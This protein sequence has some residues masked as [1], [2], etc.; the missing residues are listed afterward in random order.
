MSLSFEQFIECGKLRSQMLT[1]QRKKKKAI[2]LCTNVLS[3][4]TAPYVALSGGKDSVAMAF[5][6]ND[7]AKKCGKDFRLWSHISDASF[8]GTEETCEK[9]SEMIN[10]PLDISRSDQA[11]E[12]L[13]VK[14]VTAFGKKGVFFSEVR[15]YNQS[16][17]VVFVGVRAGESK[18]RMNAAKAH[19][20]VFRSESMGGI[21]VVN[22]LQWFDVFDVAAALS[23]YNAPIH[24]I[25]HKIPVEN[26]S[27]GNGEPL[28]IRLSYITSKDLWNRGTLVFIKINYPDIYARMLKYCP[29]ISRY[30]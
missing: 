22:P 29:E 21:S 16:K 3:A 7:A 30:T 2:E 25:Y 19:G 15:R 20:T 8:P 12:M 26:G 1:Y 24:P 5:I 27:N 23:E 9:V 13:S 11:F 14:D 28:F 4:H 18:R 6:V 10:R 17:D